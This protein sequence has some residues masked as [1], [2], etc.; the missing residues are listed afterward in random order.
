MTAL[1]RGCR[2]SLLAALIA[3]ASAHAQAQSS[4][5]GATATPRDIAPFDLTGYWTAVVTEDWRWRMVTPQKGDYASVP[6]NAKG[7]ALADTWDPNR[8]AQG[9]KVY[10][11][12]GVMRLPLRLRISWADSRTLTIETDRGRQTRRLHFDARARRPESPSLQGH[13]TASWEGNPGGRF[14][15]VTVTPALSHLTVTTRSLAPGFLR[16][17]G[18]PYSEQTVLTEYFDHH[19]N[20]GE[21]WLTVTSIVED[22][23]Y[24]N[25]A[26][27][28][29][30]DFK[31]LPDGSSW[32]PTPCQ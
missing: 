13:S 19:E 1:T 4:A 24:L 8:P 18:V 21:S 12:P 26:F 31:R 9:C 10:G 3:T 20:F 25:E 7:R 11:A 5:T 28:T 29:S 32:N 22:P 14:E 27:I 2:A 15:F 30:S 16:Q 17:N 6:L 23:A